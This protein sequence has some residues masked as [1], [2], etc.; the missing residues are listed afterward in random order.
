MGKIIPKI[1]ELPTNIDVPTL[2]EP[3]PRITNLNERGCPLATAPW[4]IL[5]NPL[6]ITLSEIDSNTSGNLATVTGD[7]RAIEAKI[8][9]NA[10][11]IR[12]A[13]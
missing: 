10:P 3:S 13:M 9:A 12:F 8:S 1:C 4:N 11:S 6:N 5:P 2:R 7:R